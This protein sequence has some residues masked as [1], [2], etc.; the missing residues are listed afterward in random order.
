MI[1]RV[2][3]EII[4][5]EHDEQF[6]V[7]AFQ[8]GAG[9]STN[10]AVNEVIANRALELLGAKPGEYEK[11]H[12]LDDVN[13]HQSTNDVYPTAVKIAGLFLLQELEEAVVGLQNALQTKERGFENVVK[14]ARTQLMDATLITLGREFGAF[15]EAIARDRWRIFKCGERLRV[16]N[17]G[18][19]AV[20]T[21]LTAPRAYIFRVIENL[22]QITGLN[23]ARSENL[24][25]AT[26]NA[27]VFVEVSGILKAHA[28]NLI[29]IANDLRLMASGPDAGFGEVELPPVQAGSSIMAG[30]VNPVI[31]EAVIQT[32]LAVFA[33]DNAIGQAAALGNL[34]LN[35][36]LPL[37]ADQLL[38]MLKSL[39]RANRI[40]AE[41]C[42]SGIRANRAGCDK[43]H[44]SPQ[45]LVTL[46]VPK[47]G[48]ERAAE[49][50][51]E[52]RRT[53]Q[54]LKEILQRSGILSEKEYEHLISPENLLKLGR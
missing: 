22:R 40:F 34:E 42:I 38:Q 51:K 37:I 35:P 9:T 16:V 7:D 30:K 49:I 19:T 24:V 21:G 1:E 20:G 5:G 17:L 6:N 15:A 46:L 48:Y 23:L 36:F 14:V 29:K 32:G 47:I 27:D 33:M 10:M 52:V 43:F 39:N 8:G 3:R 50:L 45:A 11:F 41:K 31:P 18:G 53:G 2:C 28:A 12:P 26:Q 44:R 4:A 13:R 54:S 25:D